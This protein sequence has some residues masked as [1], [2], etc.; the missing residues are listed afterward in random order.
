MT[1]LVN[2]STIKTT[3]LVTQACL[4]HSGCLSC[5]SWWEESR[6]SE[7][8]KYTCSINF[9]HDCNTLVRSTGVC[10]DLN[11][12]SISLCFIKS[13]YSSCQAN[14]RLLAFAWQIHASFNFHIP[15]PWNTIG[16]YL[17]APFQHACPQRHTY[18]PVQPPTS[19]KKLIE[20]LFPC[21]SKFS[22]RCMWCKMCSAPLQNMLWSRHHQYGWPQKKWGRL[23]SNVKKQP[24]MWFLDTYWHQALIQQE[25][26]RCT[27]NSWGY[28]WKS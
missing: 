11:L 21:Q 14:A 16:L 20:N 1:I 19:K 2:W 23:S 13:L 6:L 10:T 18:R 12:S 4:L 3:Q 24:K 5:S 26:W 27:H 28:F 7:P 9:R 22:S 8:R 15:Q 25:S 17:I